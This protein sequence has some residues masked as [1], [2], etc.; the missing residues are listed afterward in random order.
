MVTAC[1]MELSVSVSTMKCITLFF[2]LVS[3]YPAIWKDLEGAL[4]RSAAMGSHSFDRSS[5]QKHPRRYEIR[6]G[7]EGQYCALRTSKEIAY[8]GRDE[9]H[10]SALGILKIIPTLSQPRVAEKLF[11]ALLLE[12]SYS[13]WGLPDECNEEEN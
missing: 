7:A 4:T 5:T 12:V 1:I 13:T 6:A 2:S 8:V 3:L 11:L 9:Q 10:N